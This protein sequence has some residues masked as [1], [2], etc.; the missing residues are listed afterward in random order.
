MSANS[1]QVGGE[2]Y[3]S[4]LQHW[5]FAAANFGPGY[6]RGNATKYVTRSRKKS[7]LEDLK[8]ARH[9]VCKMLEVNWEALGWSLAGAT[10]RVC[11]TTI[12]TIDFSKANELNPW[13]ADVI[14]RI[15]RAAGNFA[16]GEVIV[17]LDAKIKAM[18]LAAPTLL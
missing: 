9:Y 7:G 4:Q 18:E 15:S 10:S 8:K 2:H 12:K 11:S 6:F 14:E 16:L 5:D 1:I 13:E 17:I 3:K